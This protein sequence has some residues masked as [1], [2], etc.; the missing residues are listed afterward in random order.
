MTALTRADMKREL[1]A[2]WK[3]WLFY[4][5]GHLLKREGRDVEFAPHH[6]DFWDAF[7][8]I[9]RSGLPRIKGSV[10]NSIL[11]VWSRDHG[12]SAS[13]EMAIASA[14]ARKTRKYA[15]Y[16]SATQ[17]QADG[18][19]ANIGALMTGSKFEWMYPEAAERRVGKYGPQAWRRNRLQASNGFTL[20]AIGLDKG[21]RGIRDEE[22]RP[23]LII[24]DDI[25]DINDSATMTDRKMRTLSRSIIPT[26]S[27]DCVIVMVQNLVL[28]DGIMD[29]LING[30]ADFL[31]GAYVSGPHPAVLGLQ[32]EGGDDGRW[33][34]TGGT[35]TWSGFDIGQCEATM[36]K[37]GPAAFLAEY[38]HELAGVSDRV[39]PNFSPSLH[40]YLHRELP[41]FVQMAGGL[42]FGGEGM[43][44][45]ETAGVLAGVDANDRTLLVDEFKDNGADVDRRLMEWMRIQEMKWRGA[46]S[47][48]WF[49]DATESLGIRAM[50]NAG[51]NVVPSRMGGN[52]QLREFR[53]RL[54]G[55]RLSPD[56]A[57]IPGLRYLARLRRWESE[58]L[59]YR[60]QKPA[61]EGDTRRREI[62]RVDDHLMT[63]T[64]YLIDGLY[65][66]KA[67]RSD[68]RSA[69]QDYVEVL[70]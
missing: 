29:R 70:R 55:Q 2:D 37:V 1:E 30:R 34:I 53:A 48:T 59:R 42:D 56:A 47:I 23:D 8:E 36:N 3:A 65:G 14:A 9:E 13:S 10:R 21:V 46:G 54:V 61:F 20:D 28:E 22:Q 63:A 64:E 50:K 62:I 6:H 17:D 67:Q 31:R 18:H 57:G 41:P 45:N 26:G 49:A 51:F 68:T 11:C 58:M 38:Q 25:D 32:Y 24:L 60:R 16:V 40:A 44:A 35:P 69:E 33:R 15:L 43:T 5:Y 12:K 39:H 4:F 52:Q 7:W 66:P 27:T 19:V